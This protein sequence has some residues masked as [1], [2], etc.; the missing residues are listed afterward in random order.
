MY[1]AAFF[2]VQIPHPSKYYSLINVQEV[3]YIYNK[4]AKSSATRHL[5][6]IQH[7]TEM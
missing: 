3:C 6:L 5:P 7:Y 1:H 4:I 2:S